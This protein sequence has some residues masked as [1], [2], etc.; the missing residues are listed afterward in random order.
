M[1]TPHVA[2]VY[3]K[4]KYWTDIDKVW[5]KAGEYNGA[6][7]PRW[8]HDFVSVHSHQWD[9]DPQPHYSLCSPLMLVE[10]PSCR[11]PSWED[12]KFESRNDAIIAAR[13]IARCANIWVV[14]CC[15][16]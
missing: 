5:W 1:R 15:D 16:N 13:W 8:V 4:T 9:T 10:H 7:L 14:D 12:W 3:T 11:R 6:C 2:T